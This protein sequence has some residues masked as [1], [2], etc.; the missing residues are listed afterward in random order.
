[1]IGNSFHF[2]HMENINCY[3]DFFGK[4][5]RTARIVHVKIASVMKLCCV[6]SFFLLLCQRIKGKNFDFHLWCLRQTPE[7]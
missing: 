4:G 6:V 5:R 1:M 3:E 2:I 7:I